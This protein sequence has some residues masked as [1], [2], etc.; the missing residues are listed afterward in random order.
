MINLEICNWTVKLSC[1]DLTVQLRGSVRK[2]IGD[3]LKE[4][5]WALNAKPF[6][7]VRC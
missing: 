5:G 6:P 1:K 2:I 3:W 7:K 4:G